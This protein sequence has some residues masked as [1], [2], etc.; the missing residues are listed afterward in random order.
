MI[1]FFKKSRKKIRH[2]HPITTNTLYSP[3]HG[4]SW[5]DF[6]DRKELFFSI[7]LGFIFLTTAVCITFQI[8]PQVMHQQFSKSY[9]SIQRTTLKRELVFMISPISSYNQF[10]RVYIS[11]E[12]KNT[13]S[14]IFREIHMNYVVSQ[15]FENQHKKT[16]VR[17]N[18]LDCKI[19]D[20]QNISQK[21]I[22]FN[23]YLIQYRLLDI[24][25][26]IQN[27]DNAT[28]NRFIIDAYYGNDACL[29]FRIY[30]V[31]I[32]N[33][34]FIFIIAFLIRNDLARSY[35]INISILLILIVLSN[36]PF[37]YS[38]ASFPQKIC[39]IHPA[40]FRPICDSFNYFTLII[41][42]EQYLIR[43]N[44]KSGKNYGQSVL[45]FF[46]V[47]FV[48]FIISSVDEIIKLKYLYL[49]NFISVLSQ[50]YQNIIE[51][52]TSICKLLISFCEFLIILSKILKYK[53]DNLLIYFFLSLIIFTKQG[54]IDG[55]LNYKSL[56]D[57]D[58]REKKADLLSNIGFMIN[59]MFGIFISYA[60]W[61][62]KK[63][64]K[65]TVIDINDPMIYTII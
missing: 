43:N 65:I 47:S 32:F 39:Y 36:N 45:I 31:S 64:K 19:D 61:P 63:R 25:T 15:V 23:D 14:S 20:N 56:L 37:I 57:I 17:N 62:Y 60:H 22:L 4:E 55:I 13:S 18:Y 2:N 58:I 46:M 9:T 29:T 27:A 50:E 26:I 42:L 40:I 7:L 38:L 16:L 8:N 10:V 51:K 21:F 11:F 28:F 52:S 44:L 1:N 30:F 41:L 34:C 48:Y 53:K 6:V 12:I 33:F 3:I 35:L 59:N 54:L 24:D 49:S 5:I